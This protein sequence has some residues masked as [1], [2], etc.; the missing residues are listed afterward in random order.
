MKKYSVKV[1]ANEFIEAAIDQEIISTFELTAKS[2]S[3]AAFR[4]Q[5]MMRYI[6]MG[7]IED[8][9]LNEGLMFDGCAVIEI[10]EVQ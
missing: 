10:K 4:A 3:A 9:D 6:M 2:E 7:Y 8:R 1:R 5:T